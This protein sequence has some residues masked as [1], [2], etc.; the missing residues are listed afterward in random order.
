M[1]CESWPATESRMPIEPD[2]VAWTAARLLALHG[3]RGAAERLAAAILEPPRGD[4]SMLRGHPVTKE[5]RHDGPR[6]A[7][8]RG[9]ARGSGNAGKKKP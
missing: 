7:V 8:A 6:G 5:H 1:P 2:A 9:T 4:R 3:E